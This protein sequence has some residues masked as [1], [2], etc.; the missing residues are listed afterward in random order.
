MR[1]LTLDEMDRISGGSLY[2]DANKP[3]I[4]NPDAGSPWNPSI[5]LSATVPTC[6][7]TSVCQPFQ[8]ADGTQSTKYVVD[9]SNGQMYYSQEYAQK[10][11]NIKIDLAGVY[12]DLV[13]IAVG[14]LTGAGSTL[15]AIVVSG[16]GLTGWAVGQF[17]ENP[18]R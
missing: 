13:T 17:S 15:G 11:Q 7:T 2:S 16:V 18:A 4:V 8:N 10:V 12:Q 9:S 14:S 1:E 3:M 5:E 6:P